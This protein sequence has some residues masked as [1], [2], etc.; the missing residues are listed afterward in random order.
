MS[1]SGGI[2]TPDK[3]D[4][5]AVCVRMG[6]YKARLHFAN[7]VMYEHCVDVGCCTQGAPRLF[8]S[9]PHYYVLYSSEE[10]SSALWEMPRVHDVKGIRSR[11]KSSTPHAHP[12]AHAYSPTHIHTSQAL[13]HA[14]EHEAPHKNRHFLHVHAGRRK[15]TQQRQNSKQQRLHTIVYSR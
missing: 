5:C 14:H 6:G 3:T 7:T 15:Y 8:I 11:S 1:S 13:A 10:A 4:R 9:S 2:G 12:I